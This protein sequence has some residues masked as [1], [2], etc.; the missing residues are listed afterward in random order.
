MRNAATT[1]KRIGYG[2]LYNWYA[3]DNA[4]G[5][6]PDGWRVP[7]DEEW[8][9]LELSLGM[10]QSEVDRYNTGPTDTNL[11]GTTEGGKLKSTRNE[12]WHPN[13]GA[14]NETGFNANPGGLG[15]TSG[16]IGSNMYDRAV[17]WSTTD[18]P[19]GGEPN[20]AG[21]TLR[22]LLY[23]S[24]GISRYG[25]L[26]AYGF[27]VRC[28][29][30]KLSGESDGATGTLTDIDG[31]IYKWVVIGDHRWMAE[32]LRTTKYK[33]GTTIPEITDNTDWANDTSGARCA[34][35]NDHYYVYPPLK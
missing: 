12:W 25:T 14:T 8:K 4:N 27:S 31:N 22:R 35:D 28:I 7:S 16:V 11:R 13:T 29:Q 34:Y 19:Q 33:N 3:V 32:N 23:N 26:H 21:V 5:L 9:N 1:G 10:S 6:A 2:W 20:S 15:E 30:N 18:V 24:S 17:F